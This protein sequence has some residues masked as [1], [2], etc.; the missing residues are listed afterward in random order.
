MA[1]TETTEPA[2][3]LLRR[4]AERSTSAILDNFAYLETDEN[5]AYFDLEDR[6]QIRAAIHAG[7]DDHPSA[8][9]ARRINHNL[10]RVTFDDPSVV[11]DSIDPAYQTAGQT[12]VDV[13]R[14]FLAADGLTI[15]LLK[16][17]V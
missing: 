6:N 14:E 15:E 10:F 3:E 2:P 13:V 7:I 16:D 4:F 11:T 12:N 1:T 5:E 17:E 8:V 9:R